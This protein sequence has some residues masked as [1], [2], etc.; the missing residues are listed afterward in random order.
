MIFLDG[1]VLG[2]LTVYTPGD[3]EHIINMERFEALT[4]SI[5]CDQSGIFVIFIDDACLQKAK[6]AWDWANGNDSRT[7]VLVAG[8]KQCGWNQ[9]RQP[10]VINTVD[11]DDEALTGNLHGMPK[12]WKNITHSYDFRLG[13]GDPV[14]QTHSKRDSQ[15]NIPFDNTLSPFSLNLSDSDVSAS[16][17]CVTC[18][19]TGSFTVELAISYWLFV[20]TGAQVTLSPSGVGA[21]AQL[22]FSLAGNLTKPREKEWTPISIPTPW[23]FEIPDVAKFG[24]TIDLIAGISLE[25]LQAE[26]AQVTGGAYATIPNSAYAEVNLLDPT[27][28]QFSSWTPSIGHYPFSLEADIQAEVEAYIAPSIA[29]TASILDIGYEVDLQLRLIDI[30]G[31]FTPEY[32]VSGVC[33]TNQTTGVS[34]TLEFEVELDVEGK[35]TDSSKDDFSFPLGLLNVP[36]AAIC[37]PFGPIL[38]I[39]D[40]TTTY[41]T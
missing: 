17:T 25:S 6:E 1:S 36:L 5:T 34:A 31:T 15:F 26:A 18:G 10:F 22:Q 19:T 13:H 9:H 11:F 2:N 8:A 30:A 35:P 41:D 39:T 40:N 7:F 24:V 12:S 29:L 4:K 33:G 37:F 32:S 28:V 16:L 38:A 14:N 27:D 21:D 20:P 3:D 23:S